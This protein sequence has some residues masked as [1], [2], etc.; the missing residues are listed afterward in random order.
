MKRYLVFALVGPFVGGFL[1]LLTTTY[2]SGYW[3]QTSLGEVGKLFA[4]FFKTLQYSYL[5][6]FLP[7]LMIGAVDD[8]LIHIRRIGPGLRMLLVGLF[9]FVLASLTYSSRGPDSGAVQFILYGLVG[10]V[11]AAISSWLVHRYV[12]EPQAAAAPT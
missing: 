4:V 5:F 6:G 8:I 2:Q 10:F 3:A 9:A 7:A 1:L 11:P 12:E